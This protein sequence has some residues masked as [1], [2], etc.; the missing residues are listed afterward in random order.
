M[1][2]PLFAGHFDVTLPDGATTCTFV[3]AP[4]TDLLLD[5]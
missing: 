5:S 1:T 4:A 3:P 2:T